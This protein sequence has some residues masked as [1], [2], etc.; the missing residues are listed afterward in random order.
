MA[1]TEGVQ[2]A[3]GAAIT[4]VGAL[5]MTVARAIAGGPPPNCPV[6]CSPVSASRSC[7]PRSNR[8]RV[9]IRF[10]R[11][12]SRLDD[13]QRAAV[14]ATTTTT[15]GPWPRER[16]SDRAALRP[17]LLVRSPNTSAPTC[18]PMIADWPTP[19]ACRFGCGTCQADSCLAVKF[20]VK[21]S[22][23]KR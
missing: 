17:G 19:L 23:G 20:R 6:R 7:T 15:V 1:L 9:V 18:F 8:V 13:F 10:Q 5:C 11:W 12:G 2:R 22:F 3:I 16:V 14:A 4:A 21:P